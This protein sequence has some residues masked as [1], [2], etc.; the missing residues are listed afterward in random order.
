MYLARLIPLLAAAAIASQPVVAQ[1][2]GDVKKGRAVA[3]EVCAECHAVGRQTLR[4]PNARSPSFVA[5]AATPGMT[6]A[7]LNFILHTSHRNMPN[8]VLNA[9][10]TAEITAYILSLKK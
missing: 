6:E 5:V 1:D 10:Q 3:R 9:E 7:A 4:S 8:I 2:S